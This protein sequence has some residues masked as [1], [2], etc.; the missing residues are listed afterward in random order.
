MK[1]KRLFGFSALVA[2]GLTLIGAP[3]IAANAADIS[4]QHEGPIAYAMGG[5]GKDEQ[6]TMHHLAKQFPLRIAFS[7]RKD[8]EF[9]AD[10]PISITKQ[11]GREIFKLSKAGPLLDLRLPNG[12]YRVT[13]RFSGRTES[14]KVT[15][16]GKEAKNLYFHWEG[17]GNT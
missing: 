4:V 3:A 14:R 5:I 7:E 8:N 11:D 16:G 13:A 10:V 9:L 15:L 6:M 1:S 12:T 17:Q 2:A